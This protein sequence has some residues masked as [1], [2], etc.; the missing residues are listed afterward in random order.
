[1]YGV[2]ARKYNSSEFDPIYNSGGKYGYKLVF[3]LNK[4]KRGT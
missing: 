1:M 3:V 2:D 4:T